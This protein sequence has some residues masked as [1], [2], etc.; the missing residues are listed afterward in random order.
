MTETTTIYL[1]ELKIVHDLFAPDDLFL[2]EF[3]FISGAT[4][5]TLHCLFKEE[6]KAIRP[7]IVIGK[8]L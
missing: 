1:K 2:P 7:F 3:S 5:I 6:Y 8:P 4:L